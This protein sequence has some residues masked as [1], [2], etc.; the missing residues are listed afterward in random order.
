MVMSQ[1]QV[2]LTEESLQFKHL[3]ESFIEFNPDTDGRNNINLYE[4]IHIFNNP[5]N[6]IY[7]DDL[8]DFIGGFTSIQTFRS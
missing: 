1:M 2:V 5:E 3:L 7:D 6:Y 8:S 4:D